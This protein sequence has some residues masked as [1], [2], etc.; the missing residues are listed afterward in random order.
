MSNKPMETKEIQQI[1][2]EIY[3]VYANHGL[4][5]MDDIGERVYTEKDYNVLLN[6]ISTVMEEE[7]K[8]NEPEHKN[9]R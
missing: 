3:Q 4:G 8:I 9:S 6:I 2:K 5:C 1:I 7:R